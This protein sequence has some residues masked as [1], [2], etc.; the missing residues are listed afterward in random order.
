MPDVFG[1]DDGTTAGT[2]LS[3]GGSTQ[4]NGEGENLRLQNIQVTYQRPINFIFGLG[5]TKRYMVVGRAQGSFSV[6]RIV[7]PAAANANFLSAM[8]DPCKSPNG[9]AFDIKMGGG[10]AAGVANQGT[11]SVTLKLGGAF[12]TSVGYTIQAQDVMINENLQ[13]VCSTVSVA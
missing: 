11:N 2:F 7:G 13:G 12:L 5:D 4:V 10:C 8:A 1:R 6:G 3:E 9:A